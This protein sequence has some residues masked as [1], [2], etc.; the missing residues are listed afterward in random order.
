MENLLEEM[1]S[2]PSP[3]GYEEPMVEK[4]IKLLPQECTTERDN[5]GSLYLHLGKREPR[6]TFLSDMDESATLSVD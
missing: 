2:V 3:T 1:F 6:M 4:I 5:M